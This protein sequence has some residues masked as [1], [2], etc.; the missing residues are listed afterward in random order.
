MNLKK[1]AIRG[2]I[3]LAV[4]VAL[5]MFLSG[6]IRTITTAKVKMVS[7]RSGKLEEKYE[8]TGKLT[9]PRQEAIR[10]DIPAGVSITVTKVS[11]RAGYSVK[12]GDVLFEAQV[13]SYESTMKGYQDAYDTAS[14]GLMALEKKSADLRIRRTDQE[15]A[16]AYYALRDA[17]KEQVSAQLEVNTLLR[18]EHLTLPEEGY[19]EGASE[20]LT[21][22]IDRLSAAQE[23]L[24]DAES[25]FAAASRYSISEEAFSYIDEKRKYEKAMEQALSDMETLSSLNYAV[26]TVTAPHK[27]YVTALEVA[28]GDTYDGSKPALYI[29]PEDEKPIL[30]AS[31]DSIERTVS[32]GMEVVFDR[33][34]YGTVSAKVKAAE[35]SAEGGKYI[36]VEV[37]KDIIDA[38]GSVYSMMSSD[39][40]M[41][42]TY[43]AKESTTLLPAAAVHGSDQD[44]YVYVVERENATFGNTRLTVHKTTVTVLGEVDGIVSIQEDMSW[45]TLAYMEDRALNDGDTVMEYTN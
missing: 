7:P 24:S 40:P 39:V 43:K 18:V 9:F 21:A 27:G 44:R 25:A 8:L 42:L 38:V 5:C 35:V 30:R 34:D 41:R 33:R 23:A 12:A 31:V 4:V 28:V 20:A 15:Y 17:Q 37:D 32:K 29:T 2:L 45:Q 11:T 26:A 22:A 1:F 3:T 10:V 16:D 6:T 36:D 19:P 13:T 14:E